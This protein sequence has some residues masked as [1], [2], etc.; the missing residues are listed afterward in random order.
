LKAEKLLDSTVNDI[1]ALSR[2]QQRKA[3]KHEQSTRRN[4]RYHAA[5]Q[6]FLDEFNHIFLAL[7]H[8]DEDDVTPYVRLTNVMER[9][10]IG[11]GYLAGQ[12]QGKMLGPSGPTR[13]NDLYNSWGQPSEY[14]ISYC[15]IGLDGSISKIGHTRY[16]S[17]VHK[18]RKHGGVKDSELDNFRYLRKLAQMRKKAS[19]ELVPIITAAV[20]PVLNPELAEQVLD[21]YLELEHK[22]LELPLSVP[23]GKNFRQ[24]DRLNKTESTKPLHTHKDYLQAAKLCIAAGELELIP[25]F[26]DT[27]LVNPEE[28]EDRIKP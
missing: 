12:I 15:F 18:I 7:T 25:F 13:R 21:Y 3:E 14:T 26:V 27:G 17:Y 1:K 6:W 11:R 2:S 23:A 10:E 5:R 4:E 8:S 20:D 22:G 9:A 28:L 19:D 24:L 16:N